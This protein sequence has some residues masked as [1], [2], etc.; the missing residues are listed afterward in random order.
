MQ[1]LRYALRVLRMS[2][3]FTLS[4]ALVLALGIGANTAIFS[5]VD[6]ALL[7]PLPFRQ[8]AGLVM[9]YEAP[10]GYAYNRVSRST[11]STGTIRIPPSAAWLPISG[12]SRTM[13]TRNG[14]ER[15]AG[16]SVTSEFF[17][18]LGV[19]PI[20]GRT[21]NDADVARPRQCRG[22]QRANVAHALRAAIPPWWAA[23]SAR[24]PAVHGDRHRA[25]EPSRSSIPPNSGPCSCRAANRSSAA[26]TTSRSSAASSP[27]CPS[28]R[29]GPACRRSRSISRRSRPQTN[30]NW[31]ITLDPLRRAI[32][33]KEL[34]DTSLVLAGV[35]GFVLL[36]ACAN[37]ANLML[38]RGAARARE[39][40]VRASL[41]AG[42]HAPR[43]AVAHRKPAAGRDRRG[44]RSRARPGLSSASRPRSFHR[45]RCPP[46]WCWNSTRECSASPS[47]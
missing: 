9:L 16:Q 15:I 25:R 29:P 33:G 44:G 11:S 34:R 20:A 26:C 7:R 2:P 46:A 14:A 38:A 42:Q 40:A 8:P 27:A 39:M 10:P 19:Q 1:D 12:G 4:A 41:G 28:S 21:F 23:A 22:P 5:V 47:P 43:P 6:A 32:V 36:M 13:Q 30:K 31:G 35:V 17:S 45:A 18:L 24:R 37:V 3:G